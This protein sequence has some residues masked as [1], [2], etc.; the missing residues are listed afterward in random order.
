MP[1]T[2]DTLFSALADPTRRAIFERLVRDGEQTIRALTDRARVSQPAVSKHLAVLKGA[3]LVRRRREGRQTH[4]TAQPRR[5]APLVDWMSLH[6][7]FWHH[8]F[9]AVRRQPGTGR[10]R[11]GVRVELEL[12]PDTLA[13][14]RLAP[15]TSIPAW[16][17]A[18]GGFVTI[19]RTREELSITLVQAAVP[20]SVPCERDFRAF[21]V[22]G[23]LPFH[24]VGVLAAIAEPLAQANVSIFSI[25]TF[26]TDYVLVRERDL[27]VA[28]QALERAGHLIS[29]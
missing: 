8:R 15:D 6:G 1:V 28:A 12:L 23:A 11:A 29:R 13:I 22:R 4:Y 19:S 24:L 25:S 9:A 20:P 18:A 10:R 16:A 3:G 14:C 27:G 26:D 5:L 17:E 2:T 21:R 7:A